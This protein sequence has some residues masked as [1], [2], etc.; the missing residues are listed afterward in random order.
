MFETN[1]NA[2]FFN[3]TNAYIGG[4]YELLNDLAAFTVAGWINPPATRPTAPDCSARTTWWNLA[5]PRRRSSVY[6]QKGSLIS[7]YTYPTNQWH[8]VAA[9]GSN[10]Q[11]AIYVDGSMV[12]S[13]SVTN[14]EFRR[15]GIL[16]Q[17]RRRRRF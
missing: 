16:F 7:T 17:H 8:F 10:N 11:V 4:P 12:A 6:T 2:P 5:L 14:G 15:V 9:T 3:G 13:K 1:N